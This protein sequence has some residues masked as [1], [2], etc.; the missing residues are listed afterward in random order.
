VK[1]AV[2]I[3]TYNERESIGQT[4][5]GIFS[6]DREDLLIIV[7]D[8]HSPDGTSAVVEEIGKRYPDRIVLI[9][10]DSKLGLG[11]AYKT[12]FRK[13]LELGAELIVE[14]DADGSHDPR[15]LPAL[16]D[17]ATRDFDVAIGSRRIAGGRIVGWGV[18]RRLM[19][20]GAMWVS[21]LILGLKPRDVTSG[22]RCYRKDVVRQLLAMGVSS[23]GYAFQEETLYRCQ[24]LGARIVEVPITFR[25]RRFGS[26][27]LSWKDVG[28]FFKL[29]LLLKFQKKINRVEKESL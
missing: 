14:M 21:R 9:R 25:E 29:M 2:C 17:A 18:H 15:D 12:G 19:S 24:Q 5:E 23:G 27:K 6:L 10:R 11:S 1:I 8:D 4:I 7:I 28:E 26:T 20:W 3:P 13:S 16:I 22:F